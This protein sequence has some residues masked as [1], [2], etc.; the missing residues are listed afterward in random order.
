MDPSFGT[1]IFMLFGL[2]FFV[3]LAAVPLWI[4]IKVIA[5]LFKSVNKAFSSDTHR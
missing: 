1:W 2:A 3:I 5:G 4:I